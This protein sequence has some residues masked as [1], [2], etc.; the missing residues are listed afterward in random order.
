MQ[1]LLILAARLDGGAH[2][3]IDLWWLSI[4]STLVLRKKN[5][6]GHL[7]PATVAVRQARCGCLRFA[8]HRQVAQLDPYEGSLAH[9]YL[10]TIQDHLNA[11]PAERTKGKFAAGATAVAGGVST[12]ARYVYDALTGTFKV[13]ANTA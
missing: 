10:D 6:N 11:P 4:Q 8:G 13:A 12:G 2:A 7:R 3:Q 9:D 5:H 1:S